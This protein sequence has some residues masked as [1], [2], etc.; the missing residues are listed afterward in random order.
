MC[1]RRLQSIALCLAL[2]VIPQ[3]AAAQSAGARQVAKGIVFLID[4]SVITRNI[5]DPSRP[6]AAAPTYGAFQSYTGR[7]SYAR[8]RGRLDVLTVRPG[9]LL[10][11]DSA[12]VTTPLAAPGDYYLF[13]STTFV[14]VHTSTRTFSRSPI[15]HEHFGDYDDREG[16]PQ[17]FEFKRTRFDTLSSTIDSS[18]QQRGLLNVYWHTDSGSTGFARGRVAILDVPLGELNVARWLGA[19]RWLARM[20]DSGRAAP[21]RLTVTVAVPYRAPNADGVPLSFILTQRFTDVEIKEVDLTS[22]AVPSGY[23]EVPWTRGNARP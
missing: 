7:M 23:A 18:G 3:M 20:I 15:A 1:A 17:F 10:L 12:A 16:W 22:F 8:G 4:T 14:L 6:D 9:P 19:T 5:A 21:G 2:A 13:D 11:A